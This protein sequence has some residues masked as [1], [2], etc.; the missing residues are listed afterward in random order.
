VPEP[1]TIDSVA[2]NLSTL[3]ETLLGDSP[4]GP[5][6]GLASGSVVGRYLLLHAVG[7]GAMGVVWAAYDPQLDRKVAIKVLQTRPMSSTRASG[8]DDADRLLREAK[9]LAKLSHPNVV[10]VHDVGMHGGDRERPVLF[11]AMEYV[12]GRTLGD[13]L[14][15]TKP[16]WSETLRILAAAGDGVAAAH[17]AG[18]VHRDLK[19]DNIMLGDDGRVRVMD[20]GLA[21][22][23]R[24][25]T[26][27][28]E[29]ERTDPGTNAPPVEPGADLATQAG[30]LVGTP[31]YMAPEQFRG[32]PIDARTD[33]FN[34]CVT[35]WEALFGVRPFTG[36]SLASLA[37]MVVHGELEAPPR[38]RDVPS[39][40]RAVL[41]QGLATEREA[42]HA[43]MQA[44]LA[45]LRRGRAT[46]ARRRVAAVAGVAGVVALGGVGWQRADE[47][48]AQRTCQQRGQ[49]LSARWAQV[50]ASVHE[51]LLG[52]G[53]GHAAVTADKVA[54]R[55]DDY[56]ARWGEART[57]V[58]LAGV[59]DETLDAPTHARALWCLEER[60]MDL[61]ALVDTLRESEAASVHGAI[62]AASALPGIDACRDARNLAYATPPPPASAAAVR[63][64]KGALARAGAL[65]AA[66][67]GDEGTR[68]ATTALAEAEA[69]AWPPL[70]AAA[71]FRLGRLARD[72]GDQEAA[73]RHLRAAYFSAIDSDALEVATRA[74]AELAN[75]VGTELSRH[76]EGEVWVGLAEAH[77]RRL[78]SD[79]E[80]Q[81]A[82]RLALRGGIQFARSEYEDAFESF[83]EALATFERALGP[84]HPDVASA[85]LNVGSA[86][87]SR[88]AVDDAR[89]A[90]ERALEIQRRTYGPAHPALARS[91]NNLAAVHRVRGD[92]PAARAAIVGA[93]EIRES[94]YGPDHS[95]VLS[96]VINL[97]ILDA[98]LGHS[99]AAREGFERARRDAE[100]RLGA[101]SVEVGR[102]L[103]SL[104][105][106]S[107]DDGEHERASGELRRAIEIYEA[108][109]GP[110][111]FELA[112]PLVTQGH[113]AF[114]AGLDDDALESYA[115]AAAIRDRASGPTHP[116]TREAQHFV[117]QTLR[118][119]AEA[120]DLAGRPT[121]AAEDR[122]NA[123]IAAAA[124][125]EPPP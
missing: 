119:R 120:H 23:R 56:T 10:T 95:K 38:D 11:I 54:A 1:G 42:R 21:R 8:P 104:G 18:L 26:A 73:E 16:S 12:A 96:L 108:A 125:A 77:G 40:V 112:A 80:L 35:A 114:K 3:G 113:I 39:W 85:A 59:V 75:L 48:A 31:A 86:A 107:F 24:R 100:R 32:E 110:D 76:D 102:A 29:V 111:H 122:R 83:G 69:L 45:A 6:P 7:A 94:A 106:L 70:V 17:A 41:T 28:V 37:L 65:G 97:A 2:G 30:M 51:R 124:A 27:A 78:E 57:A 92:L 101:E 50:R 14:A 117:A 74:A 9:A 87:F 103:A 81:A 20:F 63:A 68:L 58:C 118:R 121:E 22:A 89:A 62:D 44:L 66:A 84:D 47:A 99:A 91:L 46:A 25:T 98:E 88:G 19:P 13:W 36:E 64:I 123:Q 15:Q 82:R 52:S 60:R 53:V 72:S 4:V 115:R 67:R 93:L 49:E 105:S 109:L 34:F 71:Q 43:S 116:Q 79:D 33:Q 90:F 5:P 55:L 61:S